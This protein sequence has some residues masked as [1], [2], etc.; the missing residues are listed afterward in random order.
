MMRQWDVVLG[1]HQ[2]G[3]GAGERLGADVVLPHPAQP[4]PAQRRRV[5]PD[6]RLEPG[7]AGLGQQHCTDAG[8]D[9]AGARAAFAG[10]REPGGEAGPG[11][12]FQ[13]QLGQVHA[14]HSRLDRRPE[15]GEAGWLVQLV[16]GGQDQLVAVHPHT[17]V[18]GQVGGRGAVG[19]VQ[20]LTQSVDLR[21][22]ID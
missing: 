14:R 15:G 18:L 5:Q 21:A 9:V 19:R 7:I 1:G 11:V 3:V 8:R 17:G 4:R 6:Q 13:Q 12:H 22:G 2:G 20:P 16:E 10:M